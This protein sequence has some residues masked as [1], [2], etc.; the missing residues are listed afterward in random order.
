M[1]RENEL[2]MRR[3]N[4]LYVSNDAPRGLCRLQKTMD[5]K[6]YVLKSSAQNIH[7]SFHSAGY[8]YV[9]GY[10]TVSNEHTVIS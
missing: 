2:I 5:D 3:G 9:V 4:V 1:R 7:L 8:N 10:S 6:L